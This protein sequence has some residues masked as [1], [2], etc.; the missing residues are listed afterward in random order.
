MI[1]L[2]A[3]PVAAFLLT[4][5]IH[6]TLLLLA[7]WSLEQV[8]E[9]ESVRLRERLWRVALLGGFLTAGLQFAL[10]AGGEGALGTPVA[11]WALHSETDPA[12]Q[13]SASPARGLPAAAPLA[14]EPQPRSAE[15]PEL[16][17]R[18][19]QA[20]AGPSGILPAEQRPAASAPGPRTAPEQPAVRPER[21]EV[22]WSSAAEPGGD[23]AAE[24]PRSGRE[25]ARPRLLESARVAW[26]PSSAPAP[27]PGTHPGG[28][29]L[30]RLRA[31][32]PWLAGVFGLSVLA[33][34]GLLALSL[35]RLRGKLARAVVVTEGPELDCLNELR[36]RRT[37]CG[38]SPAAA[39]AVQPDDGRAQARQAQ[40]AGRGGRQ[41]NPACG[42]GLGY[43]ARPHQII[44]RCP[45]MHR[46]LTVLALVATLAAH[47]SHADHHEPGLDPALGA[48]AAALRE[49]ALAD[50]LAYRLVTSLA[51]E[52]GPRLAGSPGDIAAVRWAEKRLRALG[53]DN[54]RT[55]A[56]TVPHWERGTLSVAIEAPYPQPLVGTMLGGSVGTTRHGVT[57]E[58]L[59]V[60]SLDELK[61]LSA[62][63][64]SGK[65]VF[66][67]QQMRRARDGAGYSE[68][69]DN[70]YS[71]PS[72]SGAK[73][74]VAHVIRS[75]GTD[76]A[77]TAH[78]GS[79]GYTD[80]APRIPALALSA[81]DADMLTRQIAGGEPVILGIRSSARLLPDATSYNVMGDITGRT[82][83]GEIVLLGAH[84]DSWDEGTGAIDDGSGV[85]IVTA[86][87]HL[88]GAVTP[89]PRRTVRVVLFANEEF[90]LS[91]AKQY[92]ANHADV[93]DRHIVG[94][95][96]DFGAGAVWQFS[97]NVAPAALDLVAAIAGVLA[98]LG[99]EHGDN[100]AYG[101][102][103]IGP[104]RDQGMPVLGL[105]QDGTYYFD[106]HHTP[107]DTLDKI[108]EADLRQN[109]AA[110]AVAALLAASLERDFGRLSRKEAD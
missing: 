86:A 19:R 39:S 75:V 106:Y 13:A 71:G 64:V 46:I 14:A 77:R 51:T 73:G 31:V 34:L 69:V 42:S 65:I 17:R 88:I 58:V 56:V 80:D 27:A 95:E 29:A 36:R 78:T 4:Y 62:A 107:G 68:T 23:A 1:E 15:R 11:R 2:L 94:M 102:A 96:A 21:P 25:P 82:A 54:V 28:G 93:L 89:R 70:R 49:R 92:L 104:L 53:F 48:R 55:E 45:E 63:Q 43:T 98:P 10:G 38:K 47:A 32:T 40:P 9:F 79:L 50:P 18:G 37:G 30:V 97:S 35:G 6:S 33:A 24:S 101:G 59:R 109:V 61:A 87:A 66:I 81:P 57:A 67:D 105:R 5:L 100:Q 110:Y 90:G 44:F 22:V 108:D 8:F 74:A 83:P 103:D 3:L 72:V 20:P 84:L 7:A 41:C 26:S 52:V 60:T 12:Q 76:T 85:A 16:E 99:I 91:G